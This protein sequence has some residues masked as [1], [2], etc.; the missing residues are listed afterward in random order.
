[1]SYQ[2]RIKLLDG[3]TEYRKLR[4]VES[5]IERLYAQWL[6]RGLVAEML[7]ETPGMT[8]LKHLPT[9]G[10]EP[11]DTLPHAEIPGLKFTLRG[12][13]QFDGM[14]ARQWLMSGME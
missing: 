4:V 3:R 14:A 5:L 11:N 6:I 8:R 9:P 7:P 12:R 1:M 10:Q 2:V 13:R